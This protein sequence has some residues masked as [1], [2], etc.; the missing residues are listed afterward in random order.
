MRTIAYRDWPDSPTC[1]GQA[2][3]VRE[4]IQIKNQRVKSEPY[5][6]IFEFLKISG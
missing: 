3:A 4:S 5:A 6:L 1:H 2:A